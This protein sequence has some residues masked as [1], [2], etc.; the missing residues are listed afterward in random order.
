ML[1][2]PEGRWRERI[3]GLKGDLKGACENTN[4]TSE[5]V[6]RVLDVEG[7]ALPGGYSHVGT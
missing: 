6:G 1:G 4:K 5:R 7:L 3:G 2:G